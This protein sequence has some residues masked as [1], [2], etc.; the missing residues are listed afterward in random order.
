MKL[1]PHLADKEKA[2]YRLSS[3]R[4]LLFI[5]QQ[6]ELG[7]GAMLQWQQ[8]PVQSSASCISVAA[9]PKQ[10]TVYLILLIQALRDS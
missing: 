7:L 2:H 8:G 5:L 4:H 1:T 3:S 9:P 6:R 10:Q